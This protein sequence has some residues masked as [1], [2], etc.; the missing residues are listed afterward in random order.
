MQW[1]WHPY[2]PFG[3]LTI[4]QGDPGEGKTTLALRLAA[5]CATGTLDFRDSFGGFGSAGTAAAALVGNLSRLNGASEDAEERKREMEAKRSADNLGVAI[6][7]AI[8]A[9]EAMKERKPSEK[10]QQQ[11]M[12]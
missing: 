7:L 4:I 1:L 2:I 3:K 9:A 5:A 11:I 10:P 6:G 8:A 12:E